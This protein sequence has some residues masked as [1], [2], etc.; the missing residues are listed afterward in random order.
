MVPSEENQL[1]PK[2]VSEAAGPRAGREAA[3]AASGGP[4]AGGGGPARPGRG[5]E[6]KE[7]AEG[8]DGSRAEGAAARVSRGW[9]LRQGRP[10]AAA[11][12]RG[13]FASGQR[14]KIR[15]CVEEEGSASV[16]QR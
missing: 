8:L 2:E 15:A 11:S 5:R 13:R 4:G 16:L 14:V 3:P 10:L 9:C 6:G 7:G 12:Q 1:V